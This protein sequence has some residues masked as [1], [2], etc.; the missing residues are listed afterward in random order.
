M[1]D[2]AKLLLHARAMVTEG[3]LGGRFWVSKPLAIFNR[4][5]QDARR[6]AL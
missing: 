4:F 3:A 6:I 1:N 5:E 2:Q